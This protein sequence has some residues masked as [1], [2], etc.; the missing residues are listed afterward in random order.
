MGVAQEMKNGSVYNH[1]QFLW[2][3]LP[4]RVFSI[5][6]LLFGY[7]ELDHPQSDSPFSGL[8]DFL[9]RLYPMYMVD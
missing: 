2:L 1:I 6:I 8:G 3:A 9:S 5:R 4:T 7:M